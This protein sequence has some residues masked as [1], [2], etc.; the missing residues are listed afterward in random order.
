MISLLERQWRGSSAPRFAGRTDERLLASTTK[1]PLTIPSLNGVRAISILIVVSAHSGLE[2]V[3]PG[4]F[5]VTAFFFLSGYLITTLLLDEQEKTGKIDIPSFYARR[6]FRLVPPLVITLLIAYGLVYERFLPG[7]VTLGGALAQLFYF[8]NYYSIYFDRPDTTPAGTTI[9]WSLAVEEH[10]YILYPLILALLMRSLA[11]GKSIVLLLVAVCA[12]V[13]AW[14][15]VL[16]MGGASEDRTYYASDTRIDSIVY[17]CLLALGLNPASN[18]TA[19]RKMSSLQWTLFTAS[20]A[21]LFFTF[22]YRGPIFRETFRYSLQG[23][24]LMPIFYF[25]VKFHTNPVFRHLNSAWLVKLGIYSYFIYLSHSV[26]MSLITTRIPALENRFYVL[27]P[28]AL[29]LSIT[30]AAMIDR[31]VDPYFR[32]LRQRF[33]PSPHKGSHAIVSQGRQVSLTSPYDRIA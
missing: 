3:V 16:V 32:R 8:A 14:R 4:G 18:L 10:F 11:R 31:Y 23:I 2:R 28:T 20:I 25:A 12:T 30:Y 33:R 21:C 13:L 19:P 22:L 6:A 9:L 1:Q 29:A 15:V 7:G 27:F 17:G 24:A 26:L 5:G